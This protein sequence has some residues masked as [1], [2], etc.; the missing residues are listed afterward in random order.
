MRRSLLI[1]EVN[2]MTSLVNESTAMPVTGPKPGSSAPQDTEPHVVIVGAGFGGLHCAKSLR[3]APVRVTVIDRRNHHLFQPLLYQVATGGL[4][5]GDIASPIRAILSKHENT[6]CIQ[7]TVTDISADTR[8]ITVGDRRMAYDFLVVAA[9]STSSHFGN[10][11]WVEH[12]PGL[13]SIEDALEIR[14]RVFSAFEEAEFEDDLARRRALLT[15]VVVGG[16]PTGVEL[17]GAL[18]EIAN[19]TLRG[20]FRRINSAD[21]RIL[22]V[23]GGPRVLATYPEP[24][25]HKAERSLRKLGAEIVTSSRVGHIDRDSVE[26]TDTD[27]HT[28]RIAC[29]TVLWAAGVR[30]S[31][32]AE[33]LASGNPDL[34][35]REGRIKVGD[36]LTVPYA[37]NIFVIGDMAL[38]HDHDGQ[39]LPGLAP[40]AMAQGRYAARCIYLIASA[41]ARRG[42]SASVTR[43]R[44]PRSAVL[45]P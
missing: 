30:A 4:S 33:T 22:L 5:P 45:P 6:T 18:C 10:D 25:S 26:Y 35:D 1:R 40:V 14:N 31:K 34:L 2:S 12:A 44:W 17:A 28:Q 41:T 43:G 21:A 3:R 39:P 19:E 11:S 9:G 32:L 29:R 36:N 13:K 16:G 23:E 37:D 7:G 24:L 42:P 15:F 38:A 27:G 8:T 20:D